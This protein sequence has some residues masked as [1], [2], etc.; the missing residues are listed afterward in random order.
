M[1]IAMTRTVTDA[2]ES[3]RAASRVLAAADR[4]IKDRA[5]T[6]LA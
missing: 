2:C 1:A 4:A 6:R 5:L 3:A